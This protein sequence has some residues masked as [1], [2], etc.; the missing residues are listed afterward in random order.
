MKV[1]TQEKLEILKKQFGERIVEL[2]KE[3]RITQEDLAFFCNT[4]VSTVIRAE[5]GKI[6]P[7]A[8]SILILAEALN[9][10][11]NDLWSYCFPDEKMIFD[12]I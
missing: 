7:K 8:S 12:E 2:R 11:T 10:S 6:D 4:S 9:M 3:R 1:I 5:K